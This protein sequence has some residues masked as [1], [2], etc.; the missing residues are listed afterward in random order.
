VDDR[1]AQLV[2]RIAARRAGIAAYLRQIRPRRNRLGDLAVVA[3]AV[4]AALT[5]GPALGGPAFA[6]TAREGLGLTTSSVV[7]QMLCAGALAMSLLATVATNLLRTR[8]LADRVAAAEACNVALEGLEASL[9]FG[10]MPVEDAV[11]L[12]QQYVARIPF[13]DEAP[14]R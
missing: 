6:E 8:D 5:A 11:D 12:Y 10:R 7:W 1:R 4:A 2:D 3:S 13:V 9:Q 14:A